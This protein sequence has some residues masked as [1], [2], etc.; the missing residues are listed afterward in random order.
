MNKWYYPKLAANN[1]KK[2]GQT[3]IP[4]LFTCVITICMYYI[5]KSLSLNEG[6]NDMRG[7]FVMVE[8]LK[9]GCWII[10]IFSV[11]FLFYTNS[12]LMKRR[13][14]EIGLWNILGM[15]K[16]HILKVIGLETFYIAGIGLIAGL[17]CGIL[18]EKVV[19]LILIKILDFEITL[20]F[21][22]YGKAVVSAI[23]LF[24]IIFVLIYLN[25]LRQVSLS[26]PIE[27][28]QGGNIGEKEPK[29][30][31]IL[32]VLGFGCLA[33][34]Y[35]LSVMTKNP[36]KAMDAFFLA[37]L[38]VILG[39]YFLFT[40]GSIAVLKLLRKNKRYYYKT[41]HFISVSGMLYRMKRNAVGLANICIL[42]TMVL[43]MIST[44]TSLIAG[45]DDSIR[46]RI[47]NDIYVTLEGELER[48]PEAETIINQAFADAQLE[49]KNEVYYARFEFPAIL[50]DNRFLAVSLSDVFEN[51]TSVNTLGF[52]SLSDYN[53]ATGNN[54]E[55]EDGEILIYSYNG[56]YEFD[57]MEIF[58]RNYQIKEHLNEFLPIP[59][60]TAAFYSYYVVVKD[61]GE[62]EELYEQHVE[63]SDLA[64]VSTYY[65]Y[66]LAGT[67][68]MELEAFD[69]I[70]NQ[71]LNQG[72]NAYVSSR[73]AEK[74]GLL[75]IYGGLFFLG[76]FLG[77]LFIMA[78]ILIIYYKQISE[79]YE[80]K[81]R[82]E[83]MQKVGMSHEEVKQSIRSQILT[84]FFLPL[85][86]AGLHVGFAFPVISRML[87]LLGLFNTGLFI[88][89][90][91]I[92]FLVFGILYGAIYSMTA[93]AYYKIVRRNV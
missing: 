10:G 16:R 19:Y 74:E 61:I 17:L 68:K 46:R 35:I 65:G 7:G 14:K 9:F 80:D 92:C 30:K 57:S 20:G 36:I 39:T 1:I 47:P 34:G 79:G 33:G 43:V 62:I 55:L 13:K 42:S 58:D 77:L 66:D 54:M 27:L 31:W 83:I 64:S 48:N 75:S 28:L 70:Q 29:T 40:A 72:L 37:V 23:I 6:L 73:I 90:T 45:E 93:K 87:L 67:D 88:L 4:Y 86:T 32:A 89:C 49:I 18:L 53:M 59:S 12:F 78:T 56:D 63:E 26:K 60:D 22:V 50:E 91:V 81:E 24:C 15:E 38:L 82:F 11:I 8:I 84:V 21:H 85:L 25:S 44:T 51:V 69:E 2:N 3:Y 71:L 41:C 52:I 5:M 76:I